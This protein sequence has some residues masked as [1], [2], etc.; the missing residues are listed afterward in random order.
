[1]HLSFISACVVL[2][3]PPL[4]AGA[5]EGSAVSKTWQFREK[6]GKNCGKSGDHDD[7]IA[8]VVNQRLPYRKF[9]QKR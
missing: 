6:T 3:E 1:M 9:P 7:M 2:N 4:S 8:R 5:E